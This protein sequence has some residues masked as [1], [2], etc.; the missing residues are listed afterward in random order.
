MSNLLRWKNKL[1]WSYLRQRLFELIN[2]RKKGM[3][4]KNHILKSSRE[5]L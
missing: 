4:K 2:K 5:K 3:R 1:D